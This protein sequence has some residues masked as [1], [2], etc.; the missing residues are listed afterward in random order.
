MIGVREGETVSFLAVF[1]G[2]NVNF[3]KFRI[4]LEDN[5][6]EIAEKKHM[7]KDGVEMVMRLLI[8]QNLDIGVI[9]D[10]DDVFL[11][12]FYR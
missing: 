6:I 10:K 5:S 2:D 11:T 4:D 1:T 8:R 3:Y 9:M 12:I 7:T